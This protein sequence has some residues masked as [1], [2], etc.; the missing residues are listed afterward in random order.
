M[1]EKSAVEIEPGLQVKTI[2][3]INMSKFVRSERF[4]LKYFH[5][6]LVQVVYSNQ[7]REEHDFCVNRVKVVSKY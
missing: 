1:G 7:L 5:Y 4:Q 6:A 2:H 3:F